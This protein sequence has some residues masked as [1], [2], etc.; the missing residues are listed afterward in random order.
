MNQL[1]RIQEAIKKS[2]LCIDTLK[3][4]EKRYNKDHEVEKTILSNQIL[5]LSIIEEKELQKVE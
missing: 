1:K 5:L 3:E 4:N 2:I